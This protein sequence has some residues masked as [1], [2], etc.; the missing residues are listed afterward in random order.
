VTWLAVLN[1]VRRYWKLAALGLLALALAVQTVRLGHE[2]NLLDKA[3]FN[4]NECHAGRIADRQAY[5]DAQRKARELNDAEVKRIEADQEKVNA[6]S[7]SRYERDLARLRAG[8]LRKDLAA[9]RS[10]GGPATGSVPQA[11]CR[12]DEANVCVDRRKL[13]QAAENELTANALRDWIDDQL[14]VK[15]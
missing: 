13:L 15:R 14:G 4:L 11:T 8:G 5:E 12:D 10:T 1:I 9:P 7:K 3:R 6:E 2:R